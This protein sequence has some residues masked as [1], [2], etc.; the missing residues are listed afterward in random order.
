MFCPLCGTE[1]TK[2]EDHSVSFN[3]KLQEEFDEKM[4]EWADGNYEGKPPVEPEYDHSDLYECPRHAYWN[5]H[6]PFRGIRS[7]RTDSV[8]VSWVK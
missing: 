4:N 2:K 3:H 6:N 1:M 5:V 8:S 7:K